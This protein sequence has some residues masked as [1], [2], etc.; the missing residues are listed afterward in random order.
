MTTDLE[1]RRRD[2]GRRSLEFGANQPHLAG[3]NVLDPVDEGA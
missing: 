1:R 2:D 3:A